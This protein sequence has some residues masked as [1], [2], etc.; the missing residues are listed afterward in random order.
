VPE[1]G[2]VCIEIV[3]PLIVVHEVVVGGLLL[4][5]VS[6]GSNKGVLGFGPQIVCCTE[7]GVLSSINLVSELL[8]LVIPP[9]VHHRSLN[10]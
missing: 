8:D 3:L 10:S 1:S 4:G 5:R 7:D 2:D 9:I 6:K